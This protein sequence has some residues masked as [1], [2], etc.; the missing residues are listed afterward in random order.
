MI[1]LLFSWKFWLAI[2][3]IIVVVKW[4][5]H[6]KKG[7]PPAYEEPKEIVERDPEI[8]EIAV[9]I[10]PSQLLSPSSSE[11]EITVAPLPS[12]SSEEPPPAFE[13]KEEV[14]LTD[15]GKASVGE[16]LTLQA[17]KTILGD[18]EIVRNI[19]PKYLRNPKTG[20]PMEIDC[21]CPELKIG[22]E[23]NGIGHY[24]YPNPFHSTEKEFEDQVERDI[25]K[26]Q[27]ADKHGVTIFTV[28][29]TIDGVRYDE[30]KN[31]YITV[32][33]TRQQRYDLILAYLQ[34]QLKVLNL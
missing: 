13:E 16:Y 32:K 21:Y 9:S 18:R 31:K 26:R 34:D 14:N 3:V 4:F 29:C 22:V 20:Y 10:V 23:Y 11:E 1:N 15:N 33:R 5:L 17:L 25:L 2:V 19:R 24:Q 12:P 30:K 7:E 6:K 27:L 8:A 28:P